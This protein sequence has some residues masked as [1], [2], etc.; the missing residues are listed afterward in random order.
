MKLSVP[1]I[2]APAT[3]PGQAG[4]A[5]I[6]ISGPESLQVLRGCFS[7]AG[8]YEPRRM[9]YGNVLMGGEAVDQALAVYFKAP[10]SYTG[11]DMAELQCHGGQEAVRAVLQAAFAAGAVP[12]APGEYSKRAFLNGRLDLSQAEA[13]MDIISAE[14]EGARKVALGQLEGRLGRRVSELQDELLQLLAEIEVTVDYP[15]DDIEERTAQGAIEKL[16]NVSKELNDLLATARAGKALREGVRCAIVGRPNTGKSSL[17]NALLGEDR[18]IVT[19]RPGTTRDTLDAAADIRGLPVTFIDTAGIRY[20]RD[21]IEAIGV[22]RAK[23]ALSQASLALLVLD[24]NAGILQGDTEI[25]AGVG[26][27]V[28][29]IVAL[30]KADLDMQTSPEQASAAF[31]SCGVVAVSAITGKGMAALQD[32]I[33]ETCAGRQE[34]TQSAVLSNLRHIEAAKEAAEAL[35]QASEALKGGFPPDTAATDIRRAW[36]ALGQ[37]TGR[38]VDEDVIDLI[39]ERFCLGK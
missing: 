36:H 2:A 15:E 5:V 21:E 35:G 11:E 12:A 34:F 7:H 24:A 3:A 33:F 39:F 10:R 23:K 29:L 26:A 8:D 28:P 30:N 17:L 25:A 31:P 4:I 9:Y 6:R 13:V 38:T 27:G 16:D 1:T 32:L 20:S 14:A 18:A 37:V 22:E 19:A